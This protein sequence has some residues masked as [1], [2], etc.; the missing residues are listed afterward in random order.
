MGHEWAES[1]PELVLAIATAVE[2][3]AAL[4]LQEVR[5]VP[6]LVAETQSP[7]RRVGPVHQLLEPLVRQ[8]ES[9]R[10]LVTAPVIVLAAGEEVAQELVLEGAAVVSTEEA[11]ALAL[12]PEA[13]RL[14]V[15]PPRD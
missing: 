14:L 13:V 4:S 9:A 15:P 11:T 1:Q 6:I 8:V 12:A 3:A 10:L 5:W 2:E 7:A